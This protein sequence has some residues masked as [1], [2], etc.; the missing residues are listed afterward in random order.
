MKRS[1]AVARA[2]LTPTEADGGRGARKTR[3]IGDGRA[4][5]TPQRHAVSTEAP[6]RYRV[7]VSIRRA[8]DDV[9]NTTQPSRFI[10]DKFVPLTS[11]VYSGCTWLA[12]LPHRAVVSSSV[13]AGRENA[14]KRAQCRCGRCRR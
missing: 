9:S 6:V 11:T 13:W 1:P 12:R 5:R 2:P 7:A 4:L 8:G 10:D 3:F 14:P